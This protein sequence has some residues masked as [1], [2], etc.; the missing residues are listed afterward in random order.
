LIF[1]S[2]E[3]H[4]ESFDSRLKRTVWRPLQA[5]AIRSAD[6]IIHAEANRMEYFKRVYG[7]R[8]CEQRVIEN[9]PYYYEAQPRLDREGRRV[10]VIYLGALG[11]DRYTHELIE[12]AKALADVIE[13]DLVGFATPAFLS[14]LEACYGN[15]PA[16]NVRVLPP[17]QYDM[18]PEVLRE[19]DIG[20]AFYKHTNLNNYYCAP[21]K[22]Y[23]Y[24]MA[25]MTVIANDFPGLKRV[26]EGERLG[27]CVGTIDSASLREAVMR[28]IEEDRWANITDEVKQRYC[29]EAQA[30]RFL[31]VVLGSDS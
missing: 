5:L 2:N 6:N 23:D 20:L 22:V 1:D 8:H 26:L 27:A 4:L 21:N 7:G 19:Y 31:E 17:V 25:G 29:W 16:E 24:L 12:A 3:L 15:S 28:I 30:A 10:R 14:E 13:L 9:F 11:L 18:I